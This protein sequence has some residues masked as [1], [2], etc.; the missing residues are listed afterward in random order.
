METYSSCSLAACRSA[1]LKTASS[2]RDGGGAATVE[3]VA[4]GSWAS[5]AVTDLRTQ[6]AGSSADRLQQR[7]GQCRRAASSSAASRCSGSSCGWPAPPACCAAAESACWLLVVSRSSVHSSA[8]SLGRDVEVSTRYNALPEL[9]ASHSTL[10]NSCGHGQRRPAPHDDRGLVDRD[11]VAPVA[12]RAP[13]LDPLDRRSARAGSSSACSSRTRACSA[14]TWSAELEDA[15]DAGEVDALL[16]GEPL[17]L[18]QQ[19]DVAR[20]SSAGPDR[21]SDPGW[22]RPSRSYVR[23][24]CG[25]MPASSAATEMT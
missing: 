1:A 15:P 13:R 17:H 5:A 22:T 9:S 16:L 3:P 20:R 2:G 19:R 23:S 7:A 18:A 12:A 4:R 8:S 21:P 24:V 11:E 10:G 25:C 6:R 14:A